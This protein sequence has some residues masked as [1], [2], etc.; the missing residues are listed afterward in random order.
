MDDPNDSASPRPGHGTRLSGLPIPSGGPFFFV[1]LISEA[2]IRI[3]ASHH[4][5]LRHA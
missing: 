4:W 1:L 3:N 5:N 2:L